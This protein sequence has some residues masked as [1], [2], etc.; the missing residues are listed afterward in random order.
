ML[1][2]MFLDYFL[3]FIDDLQLN[4]VDNNKRILIYQTIDSIN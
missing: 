4:I 3:R 2:A 1:N